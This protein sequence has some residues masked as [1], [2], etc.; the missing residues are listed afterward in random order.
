MY[1]NTEALLRKIRENVEVRMKQ[2]L[3]ILDVLFYTVV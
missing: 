1:V 3:Y 2:Q